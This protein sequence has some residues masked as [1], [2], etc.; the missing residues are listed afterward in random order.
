MYVCVCM[1]VFV[2]ESESKAVGE[3]KSEYE[4]ILSEQ[5]R[6]HKVCVCGWVGKCM[7]VCGGGG[8][9]VWL[10]VCMSVLLRVP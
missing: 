9:C 8:S 4:R 6:R 1:Y 2:Q 5:D 3:C 7:W 10:C